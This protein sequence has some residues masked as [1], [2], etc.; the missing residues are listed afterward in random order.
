ME[1][2]AAETTALPAKPAAAGL[3]LETAP[4]G[5]EVRYRIRERLVDHDLPNDAVGRT[6]AV[7]GA[8]TL[9]SA[10]KI[11][12]SSSQFVARI[13]GLTSDRDR[14]DGYVRNRLLQA[15]KYPTVV[16]APTEVRGL[17][18]PLPTSGSD[19]FD[20][21]GN[22][23]V[24][25]VTKPTVWRA[26]ATFT[27]T[28]LTGTSATAFTFDDFGLSQPRVPVLLSVADTIRLEYDFSLVSK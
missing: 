27:P 1:T 22:L 26:S 10:G 2:A 28:G 13:G 4:T 24:K 5:N 3:R 12:P 19:S 6:G 11:M 18:Y 25:G 17:T 9:D 8:I 21:V 20:I 15:G 7:T 23:T 14:R 16:L